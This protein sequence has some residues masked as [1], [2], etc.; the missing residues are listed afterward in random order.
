MEEN[1]EEL[2]TEAKVSKTK[3][4]DKSTELDNLK[5]EYASLND[6]FMRTL[7]EMQNIKRRSEEDVYRI[8]KYEGEDVIVKLL[9]IVDDFERA[10]LVKTE[11]EETKKYLDGFEMIYS[12][13]INLLNSKNVHA[14]DCLNKEFDPNLAQAV[15][16]E[17]IEGVEPGVVTDV[18]QKGYTYND[19]VIRPAMVKVSA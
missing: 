12:G 14:I 9:N 1:I 6:K 17:E 4:K 11:S 8:R 19:K 3:K 7:A 2:K 15:L 13:L 18:M 5:S 16:S 10:I